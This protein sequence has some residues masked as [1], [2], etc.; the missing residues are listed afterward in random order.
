V[1]IWTTSTRRLLRTY[2]LPAPAVRLAIAPDGS[3]LA[4][5]DFDG[6]IRVLDVCTDCQS[7]GGLLDLAAPRDRLQLS[8]RE[9]AAVDGA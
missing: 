5:S 6:V 7:A 9:R 8:A 4:V 3:N 2:T 1:R